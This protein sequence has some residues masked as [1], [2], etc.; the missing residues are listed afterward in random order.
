MSP[1]EQQATA[2]VPRQL[3]AHVQGGAVQAGRLLPRQPRERVVGGP[4]APAHG[5]VDPAGCGGRGDHPMPGQIGKVGG[6]VGGVVALDGLGH[7]AVPAG[8]R[9]AGH[10]LLD[11]VTHQRVDEPVHT[12]RLGRCHQAR[13]GR[14]VER[15]QAHQRRTADRAGEEAVREP[16]ADDRGG[17]QHLPRGRAQ[18][19]EPHADGL[20]NGRGD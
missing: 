13:L 12:G 16:L 15:R 19:V 1:P 2:V 7:R 4:L 17:L 9:G 20:A 5:L 6:D 3:A 8:P 18:P 14:L 10:A 11:R